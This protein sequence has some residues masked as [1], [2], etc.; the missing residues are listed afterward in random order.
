MGSNKFWQVANFSVI[1]PVLDPEGLFKDYELHKV[2][3]LSTSIE[4]LDTATLNYWL[5][6]FV[7]EVTKNLGEKYPPKTVYGIICGIQR[8]LEENGAATLHP[9]DNSDRR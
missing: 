7:M 4:K 5:S 2:A 6:K 9:L 8:Y 3:Q 1:A